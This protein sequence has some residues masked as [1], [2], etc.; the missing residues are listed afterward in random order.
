MLLVLVAALAVQAFVPKRSQG[1]ETQLQSSKTGTNK[2][3]LLIQKKKLLELIGKKSSR[4]PVLADP[5]TKESIAI[6]ASGV[7]LGGESRRNERRSLQRLR[8]TSTT[9]IEK[10]ENGRG[11]STKATAATTPTEAADRILSGLG[12]RSYGYYS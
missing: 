9:T 3:S 2:E 10:P 1:W 12:V 4:D 11:C 7:L 6:T 5:I 8:R